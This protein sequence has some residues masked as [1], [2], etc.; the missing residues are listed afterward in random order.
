[1]DPFFGSNHTKKQ[2]LGNTVM[3]VDLVLVQQ[4]VTRLRLK[5]GF[6]SGQ[7]SVH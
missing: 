4:G 2:T 6:H 1:M 7:L 3:E 5:L